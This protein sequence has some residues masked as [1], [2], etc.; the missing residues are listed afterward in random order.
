MQLKKLM[1]S[2]KYTDSDWMLCSRVLQTN[3]P[4][5]LGCPHQALT[6]CDHRRNQTQMLPDLHDQTEMWIT[7][8]ERSESSW[9]TVLDAGS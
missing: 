7:G 6:A 1:S 3:F 5:A 2:Y 9:T 4:K 8:G